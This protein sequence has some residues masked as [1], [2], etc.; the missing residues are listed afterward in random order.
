MVEHFLN[1]TSEELRQKAETSDLIFINLDNIPFA[2]LGTIRM[3]D[4]FRT[5][6]WR[7]LYRT[8][9]KVAYTVFGSPYVI[10]ELPPVPRLLVAYG[11]S[12]CSQRAAVKVWLGEIEAVGT[13]PVKMPRV[14]IKPLP[15][16]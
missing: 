13:L 8:Q 3:T 12:D 16:R 7:S 10:H 11:N 4:T 5:W 2:Q 14:E 6:G 9:P 1:P 15:A